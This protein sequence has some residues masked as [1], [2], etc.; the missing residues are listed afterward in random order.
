LIKITGPIFAILTPF[1][2][3]G[4]IDFTALSEYLSF[5]TNGTTAEFP[6]LS[7]EERKALVEHCRK[8]FDG[9]ILN[10]VSACCLGVLN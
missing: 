4:K 6:S 10:N 9:V 1:E 2:A 7:L 3:S 8:A 5:L